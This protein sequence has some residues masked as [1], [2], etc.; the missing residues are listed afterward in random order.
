MTALPPP[1]VSTENV[2]I[3]TVAAIIVTG[4]GHYLPQHRD[5]NPQISF[6]D[7]L[8]LFGGALEKG[9]EPEAGLRRELREELEL[10]VSGIHYFTQ[11][12]FDAVYSDGGLRQRYFFEVPI[13]PRALDS[14]VLH[15]GAAMRLMTTDDIAE[16]S[17]GFVPY[18][19]SILHLHMFL[20]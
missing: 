9:E 17:F 16:E 6:P 18:D 12:A 15:E 13:E 19:F 1:I 20:R 3:R 2:G 7:A 14:L 10:E 8:C 4:D 11:L 5:R